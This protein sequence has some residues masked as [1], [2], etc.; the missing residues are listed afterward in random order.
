[1]ACC[2]GDASHWPTLTQILHL[3]ILKPHKQ[4]I[5][6]LAS[7]AKEETLSK[8]RQ[9]LHWWFASLACHRRDSSL[10][11]LF[12]QHH[13]DPSFFPPCLS[14][15][16]GHSPKHPSLPLLSLHPLLASFCKPLSLGMPPLLQEPPA[17][18]FSLPES[19]GLSQYPQDR[20]CQ[21]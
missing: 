21:R 15:H 17:F 10:P 19:W 1:M 5:D 6:V 3:V 4:T 12:P 11:V 2:H 7:E 20:L 18:W 14:L 13:G 16:S 9:S 8:S